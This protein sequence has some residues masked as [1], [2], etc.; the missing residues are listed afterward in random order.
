MCPLGGINLVRRSPHKHL[1]H[2]KSKLV[3]KSW[4]SRTHDCRAIPT[5]LAVSLHEISGYGARRCIHHLVD[6]L[7]GPL[8]SD[9]GW[10]KCAVNK[11]GGVQE[12]EERLDILEDV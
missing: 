3:L 7:A 2:P 8:S 5:H 4:S 1:P 6:G 11:I 12:E 9:L 10:L